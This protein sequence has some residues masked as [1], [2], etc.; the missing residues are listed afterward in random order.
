MRDSNRTTPLAYARGSELGAVCIF[1][2]EPKVNAAAGKGP[3]LSVGLRV[4]LVP[5]SFG[6]RL[7]CAFLARVPFRADFPA[8]YTVAASSRGFQNPLHRF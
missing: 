5:V 4:G 8:H 1:G 7:M 6:L 3:S 2:C